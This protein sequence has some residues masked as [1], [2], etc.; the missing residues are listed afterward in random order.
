MGQI[1]LDNITSKNNQLIKDTKKLLTSSRAR[2]DSFAFVLEGARLCFDVLNSV[3]RVKTFFI[4][5]SAYDKYS[6]KADKIIAIADSSYLISD[7]VAK[8]LSDTTATQGIFAVCQMQ[9][10]SQTIIGS[11]IIALDNVQDPSNVGAIIRTAEA[12]GIDC[13]ITYNCCDIYNSKTLR[14]SMGSIL[15]M[16]IVDTDNLE[17]T[18]LSLKSNYNIYSTVPDSSAS[19]ITDI[20]F[21]NNSICVIGNEANGVEDN[22]KNISNSLITIP[23]LGRAESLN[24]SVAASITMWEMLR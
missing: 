23:M 15:R 4:T 22:I 19:K 5:Q 20:D 8:K 18:L 13:I 11:K 1:T 12:L 14:A 24:A 17:D 10:D 6:D 9:N 2:Q 16:N 3:Y 21:S 7:D